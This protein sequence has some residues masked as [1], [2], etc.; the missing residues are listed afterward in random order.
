L[1]AVAAMTPGRARFARALGGLTVVNLLVT[2][3]GF[4]TGPLQARALGPTGRGELAAVMVVVTLTPWLLNLGMNGF[5]AREM[6]GSTDRGALFGTVIVLSLV[7]TLAGWAWAFPVAKVV[8]HGHQAVEVMVLFGFALLPFSLVGNVLSGAFWGD[9]NWRSLSVVRLLAPGLVVVGFLVLL[10]IHRFTVASA[11]SVTLGAGVISLAP[12]VPMLRRTRGWRFDPVLASRALKFGARAWL[13]TVANLGN[14][15]LDQLLMAGLVPAA[16]LGLYTV[17]VTMTS[18]TAVV[19]Q[20][21]N[22]VVLPLVAGGDRTSVRRIL[23]ITLFGTALASVMLALV[24]PWIVPFL[25]GHAFGASVRLVQVLLI[26]TVLLAG[27]GVLNSALAGDGHPGDTALAEGVGLGLTIPALIVVLPSWGAMG[28]A[29]ISD[30]SYGLVFVILLIC[31]H[32]RLGGRLHQYL[33][34]TAA[35]LSEL[36][37]QAR[38]SL[39]TVHRPRRTRTQ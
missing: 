1:S 35:D 15:R 7:S 29:V 14:L 5:V 32:R 12:L 26:G 25:F 10:A 13:G 36:L 20:A 21:L 31:A 22:L 18:F 38:R 6:S 11:A 24:A 16:E 4:V 34:P 3:L 28:A 9:R 17:A 19:T 37:G 8:S 30:L 39:G 23:R 2:L 33:V 27:N